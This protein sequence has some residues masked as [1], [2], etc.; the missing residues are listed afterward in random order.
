MSDPV[1][2]HKC[3]KRN[4]KQVLI[5]ENLETKYVSLIMPG[6]QNWI[7]NGYY[8]LLTIYKFVSRW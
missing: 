8:I 7:L 2:A 5:L 6:Y 3:A 4:V 1:P